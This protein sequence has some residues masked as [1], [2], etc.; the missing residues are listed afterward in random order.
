[1]ILV[2]VRRRRSSAKAEGIYGCSG[3]RVF[4]SDRLHRRRFDQ[5]FC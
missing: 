4:F 5:K 1:M 2:P 3:F